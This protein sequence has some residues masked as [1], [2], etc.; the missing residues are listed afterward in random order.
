M[1]LTIVSRGRHD[2]SWHVGV[3]FGNVSK[4]VSR[5]RRT[6]FATFSEHVLHSSWL[7]QHFGCVHIMFRGRRITSD[8][9]CRV[10]CGNHVG[11]TARS[12]DKVQ[13]NSAAGV[14]LREMC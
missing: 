12:G 6:T 5:G 8:V 11:R 14:A 2:I 10:V 3:L 7:A 13:T 4:I 1:S 9:S